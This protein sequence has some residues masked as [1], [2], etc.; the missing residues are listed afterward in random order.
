MS[1]EWHYEDGRGRGRGMGSRGR[2]REESGGRGRFEGQR[3]SMSSIQ[4][5]YCKR[6]GHK[7][8]RFSFF[9]LLYSFLFQHYIF[10]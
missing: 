2:G 1:N 8:N 9:F 10:V 3:Q 4:C 5:Y 7:E 6:Y